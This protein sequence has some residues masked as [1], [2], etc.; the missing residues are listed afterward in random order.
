VSAGIVQALGVQEGAHGGVKCETVQEI[1]HPAML[2]TEW[3]PAGKPVFR[4][5]V[6]CVGRGRG[7]GVCQPIAKSRVRRGDPG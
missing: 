1:C 7:G 2:P 6:M 3:L 5:C 4:E